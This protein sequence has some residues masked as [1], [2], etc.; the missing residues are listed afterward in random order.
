MNLRRPCGPLSAACTLLAAVSLAWADDL[1]V[2]QALEQMSRKAA[3]ITDLGASAKVTKY[4][5]VFEEKHELRMDLFYRK[6]DLSRV[7]TY[8]RRDGKEVHTQQV[9]IGKDFVLRV[10]PENKHGELRRMDPEELKRRREDRNDPLAF[11]S[12]KPDDL[13]KEFDVKMPVPAK[14]DR[15]KLVLTPRSK[16]VKFDYETVELTVDTKTWM[17]VVIKAMSG[18]E[19]DDWSCY[20]FD[21]VKVNEGLKDS[22]FEPPAGIVIEEVKEPEPG[23]GIRPEAPQHGTAEDK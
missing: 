3:S 7:D 8:R 9:I 15:V 5:S 16:E 10:W 1:T 6:P 11:F 4:D 22:V 19:E 23:T 13:K 14:D 20:E 2:D 18:G 12:R 21:K 17:P